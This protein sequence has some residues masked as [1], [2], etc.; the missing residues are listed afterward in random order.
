MSYLF[1]DFFKGGIF[2]RNPFKIYASFLIISWRGLTVSVHL[3]TNHLYKVHISKERMHIFLVMRGGILEMAS[4]L[5]G[6]IIIPPFD[7]IND[8]SLILSTIKT[9]VFGFIEMS[10]LLH[11][12][13]IILK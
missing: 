4:V 12:F 11:L 13:N 5:S 6:S 10:Y 8:K 1:F 7:T 2:F 3:G 9:Y